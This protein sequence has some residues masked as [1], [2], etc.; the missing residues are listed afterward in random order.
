MRVRTGLALSLLLILPG[1]G[2]GTA[3]GD[4]GPS[5]HPDNPQ[6][7]LNHISYVSERQS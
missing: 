4:N 6:V 2:C 7:A 1:A 5:P 3:K